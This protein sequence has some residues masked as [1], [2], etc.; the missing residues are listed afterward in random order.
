MGV[1]K[2]TFRNDGSWREADE[3]PRVPPKAKANEPA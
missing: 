1:K 3:H 2:S